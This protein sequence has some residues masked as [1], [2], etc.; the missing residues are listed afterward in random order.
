MSELGSALL[1]LRAAALARI[2]RR[3]GMFVEDATVK[4][5]AKS[6]NDASIM[7]V[8]NRRH[9]LIGRLF[10]WLNQR[11]PPVSDGG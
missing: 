10:G 9:S 5:L 2:A 1:D 7:A 8:L 4:D 3:K 6:Q 11:P